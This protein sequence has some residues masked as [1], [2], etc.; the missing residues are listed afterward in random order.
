MRNLKAAICGV[1]IYSLP[2]YGAVA[3]LIGRR[4]QLVYELIEQQFG[5][6]LASVEVGVH[7]ELVPA[8]MAE[9]LQ[10][11]AG[12]PS[13]RIV[14]RYVGQGRRVFQVSVSHHPAERYSFALELQ[15]GWRAG[16]NSSAT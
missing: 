5:E 2:E 11:A 1:D 7:A 13:L 3:D 12:S 4:D 16:S 8:G 9:A 15:R 14:R 6:K 10:V